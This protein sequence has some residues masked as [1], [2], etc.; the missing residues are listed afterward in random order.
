MSS[1]QESFQDDSVC[2]AGSKRTSWAVSALVVLLDCG[3][4][5]ATAAAKNSETRRIEARLYAG[6][7][8]ARK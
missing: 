2:S 6:V 8:T 3:R 5:L 1:E 4:T 7:W